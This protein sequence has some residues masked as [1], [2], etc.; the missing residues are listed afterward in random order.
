[1]TE[2]VIKTQGTEVYFISFL[3]SDPELVKFLCPTGVTGVGGGAKD[4]ID[5]TCLDTVGDRTTVVGLGTPAPI[6]IPY[7]FIPRSAAHQGVIAL[8]ESGVQTQWI[9]LFSDG[10]AVPTLDTDGNIQA[11]P[12]S[13]RTSV[14]WLGSVQ[15]NTIDAS[16]NE[17]VRGTL[18]VLRS[19]SETWNFPTAD[20]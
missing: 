15:E 4:T 20:L 14:Q 5:T 17:I 1:M 2:G 12:G 3:N 13:D 19:G 11:P 16:T 7:N 8:K 6:S 18:T 9:E 10:T